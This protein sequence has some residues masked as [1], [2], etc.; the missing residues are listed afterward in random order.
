MDKFKDSNGVFFFFHEVY[1]TTPPR[2]L[3]QADIEQFMVDISELTIVQQVSAL[4]HLAYI[5]DN[6]QNTIH[7]GVNNLIDRL[8]KNVPNEQLFRYDYR[9]T[10][11]GK[12]EHK[13]SY[14]E[15]HMMRG[16][17]NSI[18]EFH[19]SIKEEERR[20]EDKL[21]VIKYEPSSGY[22]DILLKKGKLRERTG[23]PEGLDKH[24]NYNRELE[25]FSM[26]MREIIKQVH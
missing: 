22:K 11:L 19:L 8:I 3:N 14:Y 4:N 23:M 7:I 9:T 16:K 6:Y 24:E 21:T 5:L 18:E 25:F 2:N 13:G 20:G 1:Q 26:E 17:Y 12:W 10:I 15:L